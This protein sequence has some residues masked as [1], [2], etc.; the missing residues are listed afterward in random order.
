MLPKG[1]FLNNRIIKVGGV[2]QQEHGQLYY[3]RKKPRLSL[4]VM[5]APAICNCD[6]NLGPILLKCTLVPDIV[7]V[8]ICVKF[9]QNQF[10]KSARTMT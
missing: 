1:Y 4:K 6:L 7:T 2:Y 3:A 10:T 5:D 8:N 9:Y